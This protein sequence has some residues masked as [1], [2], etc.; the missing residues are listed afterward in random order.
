MHA[1]CES[2][3]LSY[4]SCCL[5]IAAHF[6]A[7][8]AS[9]ARAD[10]DDTLKI[11]QGDIGR[12]SRWIGRECLRHGYDIALASAGCNAHYSAPWLRK[13]DPFVWNGARRCKIGEQLRH[14][15]SCLLH[16]LLFR[17]DSGEQGLFGLPAEF[18]SFLA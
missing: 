2:S 1:Q 5:F 12:D 17:G 6:C 18:L 9:F 4:S 7:I 16:H 3:L 14:L 11:N 13:L 10:F 8:P 15:A